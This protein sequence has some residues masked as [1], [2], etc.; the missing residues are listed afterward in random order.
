MLNHSSSRRCFI[1]SAPFC[2]Y[3]A[4]T[5]SRRQRGESPN[6]GDILEISSH[7]GTLGATPIPIGPS[8]PQEPQ[9]H[10]AWIGK[11]QQSGRRRSSRSWSKS[12]QRGRSGKWSSRRKQGQRRSRE[13]GRDGHR[14]EGRG[15]N[16]SG[17]IWLYPARPLP[18]GGR[19][20]PCGCRL[21]G[22]APTCHY[23]HSQQ[24]EQGEPIPHG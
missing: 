16:R 21:L 15:R 14:G 24:N 1:L 19:S 10:A 20:S 7:P 6:R 17:V 22:L 2:R 18:D 3:L 5:G 8:I 23:S 9:A 11:W 12:G 4:P 13:R